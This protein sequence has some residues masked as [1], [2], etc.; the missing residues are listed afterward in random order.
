MSNEHTPAQRAA[1]KCQQAMYRPNR[2]KGVIAYIP[3]T[4]ELGAII[5]AEYSAE[6]R[7]VEAAKTFVEADQIYISTEESKD[8]SVEMVD[9]AYGNRQAALNALK[10]AVREASK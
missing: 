4:T 2:E 6:Q 1:E 3:G 9:R 8:A 5:E 10:D 7:I